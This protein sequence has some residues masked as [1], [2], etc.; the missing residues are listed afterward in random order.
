MLRPIP[1]DESD[2]GGG[3]DDVANSVDSMS[4][5]AAA[6]STTGDGASVVSDNSAVLADPESQPRGVPKNNNNGFD[7]DG[8]LKDHTNKLK[9]KKSRH[10]HH[11]RKRKRILWSTRRS[12]IVLC[13]VVVAAVVIVVVVIETSKSPP[14]SGTLNATNIDNETLTLLDGLVDQILVGNDTTT[15]SSSW[16]LLQRARTRARDWIL[17]YDLLRDEVLDD[18]TTIRFTQRFVLA[19]LFFSMQPNTTILLPEESECRWLG[20]YCNDEAV[21]TTATTT[22]SVQVVRRIQ[23]A[24]MGAIGIL[25]PELRS[26]P[27]LQELNVSD[28]YLVGTL[29]N[30]WFEQNAT[31]LSNGRQLQENLFQNLYMMD[32]SFNKLVG[33][34][35][36]LFWKLPSLRFVYFSNNSLTGTLPTDEF[37]DRVLNN[38]SPFLEDIWV[39]HNFFTGSLP[40]WI[41]RLEILKSFIAEG[42]QFLGILPGTN[43]S[44]GRW[45]ATESLVVIDLSHNYLSGPIPSL[46]FNRRSL[47][48][49]YLDNNQFTGM[50]YDIPLPLDYKIPLADVWLSS[51]QLRG[52]LPKDFGRPWGELRSLL[53]QDNPN[54]RG[55]VPVGCKR[56]NSTDSNSNILWPNLVQMTADCKSAT[57]SSSLPLINCTCCT[58]CY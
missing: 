34:V 49:L 5:E 2:H 23:W 44:E 50:N 30:Q 43:T 46:F 12:F 28:N 20:V 58:K 25:P 55:T 27:F 21:G 16:I 39:D 29:P 47:A 38:P 40:S 17:N 3:D 8:L 54:L 26:L 48:Y 4:A 15:N 51:N 1:E 33:T 52:T 31:V 53:I 37:F 57:K 24:G 35:P 11:H 19:L 13:V 6:A 32:C 7:E 41:F 56:P 36:D 22:V 14:K 18:P 10:H 9:K 42:N 45:N